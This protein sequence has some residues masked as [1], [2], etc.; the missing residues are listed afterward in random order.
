MYTR[1][2]AGV[3]ITRKRTTLLVA[4]FT[5]TQNPLNCAGVACAEAVS[6][7]SATTHRPRV[8]RARRIFRFFIS[9]SFSG[10]LSP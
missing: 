8:K 1:G 10:A 2:P 5:L 6:E 7:P 3:G 9:S 4:G